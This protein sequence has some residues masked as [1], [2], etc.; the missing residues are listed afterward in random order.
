MHRTIENARVKKELSSDFEDYLSQF[1]QNKITHNNIIKKCQQKI[2]ANTRSKL[3]EYSNQLRHRV[4]PNAAGNGVKSESLAKNSTELT[5]S[6]YSVSQILANEVERS[7]DNL[8]KLISSSA[9]LTETVE[10]FKNMNNHIASSKILLSKYGRRESADRI[11]TILALTFFSG[12]VI[13]VLI[14]RLY[15]R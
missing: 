15:Y 10:E 4:T 8:D 14:Q 7:G 12:C 5:T 6:L 11:L 9:T 13:F 1:I 3:F 2:N